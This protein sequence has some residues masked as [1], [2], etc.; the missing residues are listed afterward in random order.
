M[1]L[2]H[3]K[4][5]SNFA[6]FAFKCN[7]RHYITVAAKLGGVELTVLPL[8]KYTGKADTNKVRSADPDPATA[9]PRDS[10]PVMDDGL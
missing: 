1:I 10:S 5:L 7:L 6:C 8:A 2:K 3:D 9:P 4:L